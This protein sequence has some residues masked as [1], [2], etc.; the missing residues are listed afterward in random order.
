LEFLILFFL[1]DFKGGLFKVINVDENSS[2]VPMA[3][4]IGLLSEMMDTD[5]ISFSEE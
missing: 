3:L 5:V 1:S 4:G 2:L